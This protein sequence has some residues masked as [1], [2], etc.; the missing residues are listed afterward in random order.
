MS[1]L[2]SL[3]VF[4]IIYNLDNSN[5]IKT[6]VFSVMLLIS[7]PLLSA[8]GYILD[9]PEFN[10]LLDIGDTNGIHY[11]ACVTAVSF[12]IL[13]YVAALIYRKIKSK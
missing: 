5:P 9:R 11:Y 2:C 10:G 12:F 8:L 3:A 6:I 4:I 7:F 13:G 1:G